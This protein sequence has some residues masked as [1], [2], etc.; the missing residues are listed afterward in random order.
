MLARTLGLAALVLVASATIAPAKESSHKLHRNRDDQMLRSERSDQQNLNQMQQGQLADRNAPLLIDSWIEGTVVA[1]DV[2]GHRL[3]LDGQ[4][5][6]VPSL[7]AKMNREIAQ[8]GNVPD[9]QARIQEIQ[10][11]W[12]DRFAKAQSEKLQPQLFKLSFSESLM[13]RFF[14]E[15]N[16]RVDASGRVAGQEITPS[17]A[18]LASP[19]S[20]VSK[21]KAGFQLTPKDQQLVEL[22]R[23]IRIGD[24]IKVALKGDKTAEVILLGGQQPG[25][26]R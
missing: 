23:N 14:Q 21:E 6:P 11:K 1:L 4:K 2:P 25:V 15:G 26:N 8:V 18:P 17:A 16:F 10:K 9:R 5:L 24:R 12:Q 7:Q 13:P 20:G 3:V 22:L 19:V